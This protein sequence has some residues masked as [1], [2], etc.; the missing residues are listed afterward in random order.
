MRDGGNCGGDMVV[1]SWGKEASVMDD[2]ERTPRVTAE[3]PL[4][5]KDTD[6]VSEDLYGL[7]SFWSKHSI[8]NRG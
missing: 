2:E 4:M 8:S 1:V 6:D 5:V 3:P 7:H